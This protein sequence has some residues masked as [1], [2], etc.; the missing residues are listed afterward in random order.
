[1][2]E[3]FQTLFHTLDQKIIYLVVRLG[4]RMKN[5]S[6]CHNKIFILADF[7]PKDFG[8]KWAKNRK[9]WPNFFCSKSAE[10]KI[11]LCKGGMGIKLYETFFFNLCREK[12]ELM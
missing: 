6:V 1:M 2:M 5:L 7:E 11:L 8:R 9:N 3:N 12:I 10:M 4:R